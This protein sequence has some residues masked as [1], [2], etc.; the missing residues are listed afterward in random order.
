MGRAGRHALLTCDHA[1]LSGLP[2][3]GPAM[4]VLVAAK[5]EAQT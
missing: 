1:T 2:A 3:P 4:K 5:V